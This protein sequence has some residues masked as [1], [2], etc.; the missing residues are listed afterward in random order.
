MLVCLLQV[1]DILPCIIQYLPKLLPELFFRLVTK[2]MKDKLEKEE[3]KTLNI[4][5]KLIPYRNIYLCCHSLS[6][7]FDFI[8]KRVKSYQNNEHITLFFKTIY[9]WCV[10]SGKL[11]I[12]LCNEEIICHYKDSTNLNTRFYVYK[13]LALNYGVIDTDSYLQQHFTQIELNEC[14]EKTFESHPIH[15]H[16]TKYTTD[17]ASLNVHKS[18]ESSDFK[19]NFIFF[20]G[21]PLFVLEKEK[22]KQPNNLI[23]EVVLTASTL[24][25]LQSLVYGYIS[26]SMVVLSGDIGCGKTI[27]IQHLFAKHMGRT[28]SPLLLKLQL[29]EQTDSKVLILLDNI[30]F[31]S[32][33]YKN[34]TLVTVQVLFLLVSSWHIC[35]FR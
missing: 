28:E 6:R 22:L 2:S 24:K 16:R 33:F 12:S 21:I 31:I 17:I 35:L 26:N 3:A 15:F 20:F 9:N 7:Y 13:L 32:Y 19:S 23:T 29:G 4:I 18:F 5:L 30:N 25:N 10:K 8:S 1:P 27:I 11:P 34:I 14:E